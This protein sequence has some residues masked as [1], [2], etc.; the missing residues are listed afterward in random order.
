MKNTTKNEFH[1]VL[2]VLESL[3]NAGTTTRYNKDKDIT[4]WFIGS[5]IVGVSGGVVGAS[6][7][8]SLLEVL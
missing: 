6:T 5:H 2:R 7:F 4:E 3:Y 8:Y 1:S